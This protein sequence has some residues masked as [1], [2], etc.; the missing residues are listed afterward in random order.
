MSKV[1][2]SRP[3]RRA[4]SLAR[5]LRSLNI[6]PVVHPAMR[7]VEV[8]D[9]D[10]LDMF[11]SRRQHADMAIFVS[12]EAV[13]RCRKMTTAAAPLPAFAVG[14][15]TSAALSTLPAFNN[16]GTGE[17][18]SE[19]LLRL[20]SLQEVKGQT[21]AVVGGVNEDGGG[22]SPPLCEALQKRGANVWKVA[23]YCRLPALPNAELITSGNSGELSAAVAYSGD[24]AAH[25]LAMVLP[26]NDW[27][28]R[29]PLFVIHPNIAAAAKS[30]GY[31]R[32]IVAPPAADEMAANIARLLSE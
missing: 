19:S 15:A 13:R 24:T 18:D 23:A 10:A 17:G 5:E 2:I 16:V 9:K 29:L 1:W 27:L 8:E 28:L 4:V 22:L 25:M 30:M 14:A 26:D 21:I 20:S 6:T 12:E 32:P 7:I 31:H 11:L 3:R